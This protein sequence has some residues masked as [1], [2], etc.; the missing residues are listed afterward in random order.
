MRKQQRSQRNHDERGKKVKSLY[1]RILV[2][3][4]GSVRAERVLPH[5]IELA[6]VR[7]S[8]LLLLRIVEDRAIESS[9]AAPVA[10]S[11]ASQL[12]T[13]E[14]SRRRASEEARVYLEQKKARLEGKGL[15]CEILLKQGPVVQGI[16]HAAAAH[17]A[18]LVAM[19]SH[20]RTGLASVFFGS[21]AAGV[22]HR[23]E[24][25]ILLVRSNAKREA[26]EFQYL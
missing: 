21:T 4:D 8:R 13:L 7:S 20:G 22:L 14:D 6:H 9:V 24:S 16:A 26:P 18:D 23:V 15:A 3:L 1:R 12:A 5:V 17:N 11:A 19:T 25:P 10:T 2:P